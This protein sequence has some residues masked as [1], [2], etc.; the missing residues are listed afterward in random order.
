MTEAEG[1][2]LG[3]VYPDGCLEAD[4]ECAL[5]DEE[6]C[7]CADTSRVYRNWLETTLGGEAIH[8]RAIDVPAW[9]WLTRPAWTIM[10]PAIKLTMDNNLREV[11]GNDDSMPKCTY[12][13]T[14]SDTVD[15]EPRNERSQEEPSVEISRHQTGKVRVKAQTL[16][17]ESAGVV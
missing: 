10:T 16:L 1:E 9:V 5:E 8:L 15:Q 13:R 17:E 4:S 11:S 6:H 14:T 2:N 3:G 12:Q 7:S